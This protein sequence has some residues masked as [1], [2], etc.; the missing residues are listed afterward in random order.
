MEWSARFEIPRNP[1]R[2][3]KIAGWRMGQAVACCAPQVT[4]EG[5]FLLSD[6]ALWLT[7]LGDEID[8]DRDTDPAHLPALMY[9]IYQALSPFPRIT[10]DEA[11]YLAAL[12]DLRAR[13]EESAPHVVRLWEQTVGASLF[14]WMAEAL[15][16][17]QRTQPGLADYI[18]LRTATGALAP[19]MAATAAVC[20]VPTAE[21]DRP[22]VIA[23]TDMASTITS[24]DNDLYSYGKE[25]IGPTY[26]GFNL[27]DVLAQEG[28]HAPADVVGEAI[29]LRDRCLA[30]F[31]SL[32]DYI[33]QTAS[34]ALD[35]Y[36]TNLSSMIRGQ[37]DWMLT[38][39]RNALSGNEPDDV[40]AA[41]PCC[42]D[43]R[44]VRVPTLA[45][46]WHDLN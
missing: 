32:R 46:W 6:T 2:R 19:M 18:S 12:V 10:D 29:A 23:L 34:P 27:L 43:L 44:P 42:D 17:A 1:E 28:G 20:R 11:P 3:E 9:R 40:F 33:A 5:L 14:A 15:H 37:F 45:W 31:L 26:G 21:L 24:W 16:Q 38:S 30:R 41:T 8:D 25:H 7:C 36:L 13:M 22:A 35:C 39:G 4:N